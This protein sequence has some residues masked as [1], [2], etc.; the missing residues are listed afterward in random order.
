MAFTISQ[1]YSENPYADIV[2][3]YTK[4]LGIDTVL[5]MK[6]TAD[7]NETEE[8]LQNADL[9]IACMENTAIWALFD[10]F[11]E[12]VLRSS[13]LTGQSLINA[14][15]DKENIPT[16]MRDT[17]LENEKIYVIN[18]YEELNNY[19]R[20][21]QGLPPVG[22]TNVYATEEDILTVPSTI[23]VDISIPVHEMS[24]DMIGILKNYDVL[25]T[26]YNEDPENR[27][28]LRYLDKKIN[29]YVARRASAFAPLYVPTIDSTEISDEYKERL[30]VNRR[31]AISAL[32]S[33]AYKYESD[34][35]DNFI[36]IFIILNTMIDLISR[37]QEFIARKE[38]FDLR[39]CRYIFESYGVEFFP[40]IPLRYQIRMVKNLH[41]LLKYKSTAHCMVD[42]CSL[43]GFDNIQ[44]FKY[45]LLRNRKSNKDGTY[46]FTGVDEDD[47]DLK[48]VKIPIDEPMDDYIRDPAYYVDY[49]EITTGD[50]T[51]DG[52]LDH[53]YVKRQHQSLSFN[54][55]RTKYLS[56]DAMYD[57]A[58]IAT[59]QAYFFN[60]L[61]DNVELEED[62]TVTV[63][64]IAEA[65]PIQVADLFTFLTVLTY[66][67]YGIKDTMMDTASKVLTVNGFNFHADLSALSALFDK[68]DAHT[69]FPH[70]TRQRASARNARSIDPDTGETLLA[71][72]AITTAKEALDTFIL[73]TD[74]I[75]SFNQLMN[76][77]R[78]NLDVRD[79]LIQGMKD[80]DNKRIYETYKTLYDSLMTMQ[81][82]MDHFADPETGELYR[83]AEGDA[84]YEAYLMN[85]APVLYY[86]LVEIDMMDDEDSKIQYIANIIDNAVFVLEQWIDRDEFPG[87]FHNLPAVSVDA[88]KEYIQMVV[89]FYKSYKVHFL[90]VNTIYTFDDNYEG[91][92][93]IIDDALLNRKFWKRDIVPVIGRIAAQL[94]T[95][96]KV[97]K[98]HI[99]ERIYM[100]IKTWVYK[101]IVDRCWLKDGKYSIDYMTLF[102]RLMIDDAQVYTSILEY[103]D[104]IPL[105]DI[106]AALNITMTVN[107]RYEM[108]DR[109]YY[110]GSND[111]QP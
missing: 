78:T 86:K 14:M 67:Y 87:I 49:D 89:D 42:I 37:I 91:W 24:A 77:F 93:K 106:N 68:F 39:T 23:S 29:P 4:L 46:S 72:K 107:D 57:L 109:A 94:N 95:I 62:L 60:M 22:Y 70:I 31:Y 19:Y 33:Q 51:W 25:D 10:T 63:P 45:Y 73:P 41:Q 36:A 9:Y 15:I 32:Y 54:Y 100:D 44:I 40:R 3:Y 102:S 101:D 34:Y 82:T 43:F 76:I 99:R 6:D 58:Q 104:K 105:L 47:F 59:Q 85:Q 108:H 52:G 48:F 18:N 74:Q 81:L 88:I 71:D 21:L 26:M 13:G 11:P 97:D 84:T 55:T 56:V 75:P 2:V 79:I 28:Y 1:I 98:V 8:S 35:Y 53:D 66:R 92:I 96:T 65:T 17:V 7:Q 5:K 64:M 27:G 83:D 12:E 69:K 61:Y 110:Y 20:M 111:W 80:A 16:N 38:V 50:A 90:G 103:E 30:E